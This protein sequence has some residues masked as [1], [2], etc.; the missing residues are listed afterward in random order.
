MIARALAQQPRVLLLDEPTSSLNPRNQHE[1]LHLVRAIA[2]EHDMCVIVVMYDLD[3][4]IRHCDRFLF[5]KDAKVFSFGGVETMTSQVIEQVYG[6]CAQIV[7]CRGI[8]VV[9]PF[10][11]HE[12][13]GAL[14]R[15]G[16]PARS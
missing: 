1:V 8:P 7:E 14:D 11:K 2:K 16:A 13:T 10:A 9:V 3:L 15:A 5:L 4:A 6:I 12:K